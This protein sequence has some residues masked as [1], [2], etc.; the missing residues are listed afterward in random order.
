MVQWTDLIAT[1]P[2]GGDLSDSE[3]SLPQQVEDRDGPRSEAALTARVEGTS[4][5]AGVVYFIQVSSNDQPV[6]L[7]DFADMFLIPIQLSRRS[8]QPGC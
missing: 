6:E 2:V 5:G 7:L 3:R 1:R 4:K 8:L